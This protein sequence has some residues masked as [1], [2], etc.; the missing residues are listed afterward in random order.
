MDALFRRIASL[1]RLD[2]A[3][4]ARHA[5]PWSVWTRVAIWPVL[6]VA[7]WSIHWIGWWAALPLALIAV[8]AFV[9]PRAF[10]PPASTRSW[11]SRAVLGER[12]YLARNERPIPEHHRIAAQW[13]AGIAG[14]GSVAML[15]GLV[16]ASPSL[17]VAGAVTAFFAKMWFIDRMV[18]LFDDM[19]RD[20]PDYA[21]WLR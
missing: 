20:H 16:L 18:W 5:N 10:P 14:A 21:A 9:N 4:W 7:L 17:F 13:L 12:I 1:F 3:G 6:V 2:D 8:W 19:A 11:A 15:A